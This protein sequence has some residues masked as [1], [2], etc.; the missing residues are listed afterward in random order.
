MKLVIQRV[1]NASLSS[2]G[3]LVSEIGPGL[4][5]LCGITHDDTEVDVDYLVGKLLKLRLWSDETGAKAWQSNV[6]ERHH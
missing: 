4:M 1:L 2:G 3:N 5:V 6:V